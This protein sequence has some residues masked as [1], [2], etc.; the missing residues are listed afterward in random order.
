MRPRGLSSYP[1]RPAPGLYASPPVTEPP[2]RQPQFAT[3]GEAGLYAP[4]DSPYTAPV[5]ADPSAAQTQLIDGEVVLWATLPENPASPSATDAPAPSEGVPHLLLCP[6]CQV[7]NAESRTYCHPCGALLRP[8]PEPPELTRWERFRKDC[9]ARPRVWHWD[10]RW[11]TALAALPV[12]LAAGMSMGGVT[13]AAER[14]VPLVKDRF[15]TQYAVTPKSV[16]AT[17]SAKGFDAQF[18]HDGV[19]NRAWAPQGTGDAAVGQAWTATFQS[20]FRLTALSLINGAAKTPEQ[21]FESGRPTKI[22]VTA[23]TADQ[24][25]VE[26]QITLGGQPGPQRFDLGV[27]NVISV[28]VRI[29]AVAPGLKPNMP[30]AMAE[31]QFFS[32]QTS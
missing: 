9:L 2:P 29:D 26:K 6:E 15:A 19:D 30:V 24:G 13:A 17:S 12:C 4:T 10:H 16:S 8:E 27:D 31:I 7:P 20:P 14:A 3:P 5:Q 32:R 11:S 1:S 28:Q 22:T 23:N 18:A 21:F 25:P